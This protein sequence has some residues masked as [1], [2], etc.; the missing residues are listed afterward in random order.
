MI[1]DTQS[2]PTLL[3]SIIG[4]LIMVPESFIIMTKFSRSNKAVHSDRLSLLGLMGTI[5]TSICLAVPFVFFPIPGAFYFPL[6]NAGVILTLAVLLIGTSI[7]WWSIHTLG[8]F[9]TVNVSA[10]EDHRLI[11][12]GPYALV[13]HPSYTGLLLEVLALA[14]SF[15]HLFSL[16]II[17]I[18]TTCALTYRIIIEERLLNK[19]LGDTYRVY[20]R[21]TYS[22]VPYVF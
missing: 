18:P 11:N 13:R 8:T 15:Q 17:M 2:D 10:R 6:G 21:K 5:F 19:Q 22:L 16:L 9:F 4:I 14:I 20:Q 12:V 1:I 7:R 3:P